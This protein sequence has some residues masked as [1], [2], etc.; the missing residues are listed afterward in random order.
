MRQSKQRELITP[1]ITI[2][3][4]VTLYYLIVKYALPF[5]FPFLLAF[6]IAALLQRP[7]RFCARKTKIGKKVWAVIFC[8]IFFLTI[9]A[10]VVYLGYY[11]IDTVY[12]I[13]MDIPSFVKTV[14][15]DLSSATEGRFSKMIA[16]LP[17]EWEAKIVDFMENLSEDFFGKISELIV[18]YFSDLA[19]MIKDAGVGAA[20]VNMPLRIASLLVSIAMTVIGTF[21]LTMDYDEFK[22]AILYIIPAKYRGT[23]IKIKNTTFGTIFK[24]VRAYATIMLITFIELLIG[25][26][27]L[28]FAGMD[29]PYIPILA[30][31]ISL[32]DILPVLGVGTVLIPWAIVNLLLGHWVSAVMLLILYAIIFIARNFTEPKLVGDSFGILPIFMLL[33]IYTGGKLLG[34]LGIFLLPLTIIILKRLHD[35]KILT[36]FDEIKTIRQNSIDNKNQEQ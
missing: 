28:K 14:S 20:A 8:L 23:A 11:I 12:N 15:D 32:V 5:L 31:A 9:G 4:F 19:T 29:I 34:F 6:V 26:T 36:L 18:N 25:F 22:R 21:F 2:A 16:F 24:M 35:K 27:I 1:I 7:I 10:G 33:A 13:I 30:A 3:I 17:D